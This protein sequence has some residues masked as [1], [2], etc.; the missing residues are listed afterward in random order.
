MVMKKIVKGGV[1]AGVLLCG[2]LYA[3]GKAVAP[4]TAPVAVVAPERPFYLGAGLV[5]V[6]L[7]R[8]P[9]PCTPDGPDIKDTR[10]G[11]IIRAGWDLWPNLAVELR[12]LQTYG[13]DV[14]SKTR[15][16]GVYLRPNYDLGDRV[17]LYALLGYGH[18][19]IDYTNGILS[20]TTSHNGLAYGAGVE[21]DLDGEGAHK[22]WGLFADFSQILKDAGA[23]HTDANILSTGVMYRF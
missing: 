3:G 10:Y 15:H 21:L 6:Y 16:Y 7:R 22:G 9:C 17:N 19:N 18:T 14:F 8:D 12:A 13:D 4:A 23:K 11:G 1:V 2:V 5:G 20:S